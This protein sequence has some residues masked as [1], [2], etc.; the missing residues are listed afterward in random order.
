[1]FPGPLPFF[2]VGV[3]FDLDMAQ[4]TLYIVSTPIGN[5]EDVTLR[6]LRTLKEV[7]LIAAEDT[8]RT[9]KL[10]SHYQIHTPM[11]SYYTYNRLW[12]EKYLLRELRGG[13]NVSLVS[14]AGT[15]GISDPGYSLIQAA[16]E[17]GINLVPIPGPSALISALS[18]SGLPAHNFL[19]LGFLSSKSGR[20]RRQLKGVKGEP[21]TI[22]LYES[23][24]RLL[25]TLK[26]ILE[27]LGDR[28]T[29]ITRELTKKYEEVARGKVSQLLDKFARAKPRGEFVLIVEGKL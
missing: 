11:V 17:K 14:E 7:D 25:S 3:M 13:K 19:F 21:M 8:R 29:V 27:V 9:R 16:I 12:R 20:R 18:I 2:P 10:L 28:L 4:G 22:V 1:M 23:P 6:A 15:P 26:D 24:H 5:L